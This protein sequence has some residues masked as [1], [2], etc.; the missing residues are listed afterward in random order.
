MASANH[1]YSPYGVVVNAVAIENVTSVSWSEMGG[2]APAAADDNLFATAIIPSPVAVT[3]SVNCSD[4]LPGLTPHTKYSTLSV[5]AKVAQGSTAKVVFSNVVYH[6]GGG[7]LNH[8]GDGTISHSFGAY[9]TTGQATPIA[10]T[11]ASS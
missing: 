3:I 9:S 1:I 2:G 4:M 7:G 8:G 5:T 10:W 6:G 11:G